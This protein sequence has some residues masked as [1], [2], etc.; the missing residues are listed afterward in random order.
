[1]GHARRTGNL[2]R[3]KQLQARYKWPNSHGP[4]STGYHPFGLVQFSPVAHC[5]HENIGFAGAVSSNSPQL[6]QRAARVG[7]AATPAMLLPA[8]VRR[9][10]AQTPLKPSSLRDVKHVV[11]LTQENRPFDHYFGTLAGVRGFDDPEALIMQNGR[12]VLYQPGWR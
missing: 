2:R 11:V 7:F 8:N 5:I 3:D 10:L 1:M 4:V 12:T 6:T 9:A